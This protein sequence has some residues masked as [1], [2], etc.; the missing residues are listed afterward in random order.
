MGF[1]KI[2]LNFFSPVPATFNIVLTAVNSTDL[3]S[4]QLLPNDADSLFFEIPHGNTSVVLSSDLYNL[5]EF[6]SIL[7]DSFAYEMFPIIG[8]T[9]QVFDLD[10][11]N[12]IDIDIRIFSQFQ[13]QTE[14]E[15]VW[16]VPM[17]NGEIMIDTIKTVDFTQ[18]YYDAFVSGNIDFDYLNSSGVEMKSELLF[19][20][21]RNDI[22]D[23]IYNFDDPDTT[24]ITLI[25]IPYLETTEDSIFKEISVIV[26]QSDLEYFLEDTVFVC[27]RFN[28]FSNGDQPVSG[29]IKLLGELNTEIIANE[30][31]F[32]D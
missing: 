28:V 23:E 21:D 30:E 6:V 26:K 14:E 16:M 5:N 22:I 3:T 19:A 12:D 27:P 1:R 31:L 20:R 7:P 8:D 4:V 25:K 11:D 29:G 18:K 15:G 24:K 10:F 17:E 9:T 13:F 32:H 2:E